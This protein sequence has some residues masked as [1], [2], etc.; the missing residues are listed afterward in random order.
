MV[1]CVF[2][3]VSVRVRASVRA[4]VLLFLPTSFGLIILFQIRSMA[5]EDMAVSG[6]VCVLVLPVPCPDDVQYDDYL[7]TGGT[8]PEGE[9]RIADVRIRQN[10]GHVNRA[11]LHTAAYHES[12]CHT[13]H[14]RVALEQTT[15]FSG[16]ETLTGL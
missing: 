8:E 15:P 9:S 16:T 5:H 1:L 14:R 13:A 11:Q 10:V 12:Y 7:S 4:W 2:A 6:S 3:R